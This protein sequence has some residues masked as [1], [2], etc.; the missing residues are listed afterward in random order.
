[1]RIARYILGL[2]TL[3]L[4]ISGF[5]FTTKAVL[6]CGFMQAAGPKCTNQVFSITDCTSDTNSTDCGNN[7]Y[8]ADSNIQF[9]TEEGSDE[10]PTQ[11][12]STSQP[13]YTSHNCTWDGM[14]NPPQCKSFIELDGDNVT[15]YWN[16]D[17]PTE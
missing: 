1:M 10:N 3:S 17:C 11:T 5:F 13:C 6:G 12:T 9:T 14:A 4:V 8:Y 2:S 7:G 15:A 16:E